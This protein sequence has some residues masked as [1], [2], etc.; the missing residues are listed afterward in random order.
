MEPEKKN[1]KRRHIYKPPIF[2]FHVCFG[3]VKCSNSI[4]SSRKTKTPPRASISSSPKE[5]QSMARPVM[6]E[7]LRNQVKIH[8]HLLFTSSED[9]GNI[10]A[11]C[12]YPANTPNLNLYLPRGKILGGGVDPIHGC[13]PKN[14][15]K[16]PQIIPSLIGFSMNYTPS[17]LGGLDPPIFGS[18]PTCS[19]KL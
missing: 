9:F 19:T 15:G 4:L 6:L 8:S 17:I 13:Q 10:M 1:W 18:T 14:Y 16:T 11:H 5:V 7:S 12:I 2:G 3:G